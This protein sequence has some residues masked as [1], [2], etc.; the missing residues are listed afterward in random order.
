MVENKNIRI[1]D[2]ARMAGVSIGTVDRVLHNRGRVSKENLEKVKAVLEQVNYTPNIIARSLVSKKSYRLVALIPSFSQDEYW[3]YVAQGITKAAEEARTYG[4]I[5]EQQYFNQY[6]RSS[7]DNAIEKVVSTE[8]DGLV[9]ANFFSTS[10][11]NL[12]EHLNDKRIPYV[13]IDANI[14]GQRP[15]AYY[16]T[17]S[18]DS[19]AVAAQLMLERI[20]KQ[21]DILITKIY[22]QQDELSTQVINREKGFMDYLN[23]I[24]FSGKI[25]H[26]HLKINEHQYNYETLDK[27][28]HQ[29]KNHSI[30][31][32][33]TFNSSC[34]ILANYLKERNINDIYLVGYDL[35]EKN[36]VLLREGVIKLLIGQRPE[37]QGYN[38]IKALTNKIIM[39]INPER[40]NFMPIDLLIRENVDYYKD[41]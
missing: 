39:D 29:N 27:I 37:S 35:I 31:G 38:A 20:N 41:M 14:T 36:R 3:M 7:F 23:K 19:G 40:I 24:G 8:F 32:A 26:V 4:V 12:S 25:V 15:L 28:F 18:Y 13:Y 6:D 30:A 1:V 10:V 9:I 34:H 22:Y 17:N 16:G 5:V 2:I 11:L 33:I 21:K